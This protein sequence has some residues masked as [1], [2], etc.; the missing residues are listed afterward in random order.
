V[1]LVSNI[2][3]GDSATNLRDV[4]D[5]FANLPAQPM[6]FPLRHPPQIEVLEAAEQATW[7]IAA[8]QFAE[9]RRGDA[10]RRIARYLTAGITKLSGARMGL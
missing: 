6:E 7:D 5:P 9:A 4:N 8:A 3:Y 1:N 10:R 2:G